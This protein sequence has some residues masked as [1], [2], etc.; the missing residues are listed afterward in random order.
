MKD[1]TESLVMKPA[2]K[3][4]EKEV[5]DERK[6]EFETFGFYLSNHPA[7]KYNDKNITKLENIAQKFDQ[8]IKC[9]VLIEQIR[10]I[11]TKKKEAM[12]FIEASDET[13]NSDFVAFPKIY[14]QL[15][16]L[17]KNDLVLIEGRV[18]KRYDKYQINIINIKKQLGVR[19]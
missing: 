17:K 9:I 10:V 6:R 11:E 14:P 4:S 12:A 18:T 2:L 15:N 3:K 16:G 7:S 8:Y 13:K 1:L 19:I 5:E